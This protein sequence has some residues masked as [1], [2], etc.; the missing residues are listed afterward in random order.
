[1]GQAVTCAFI[2]RP[3]LAGANIGFGLF[4]KTQP[5]ASRR[6]VLVHLPVPFVHLLLVEPGDERGSF[7][8]RQLGN[9]LLEGFQRHTSKVRRLRAGWKV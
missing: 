2:H 1:M 9:R 8:G 5:A 3:E 6:K 4:D 7:L